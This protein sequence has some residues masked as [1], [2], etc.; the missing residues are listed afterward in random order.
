M[1]NRLTPINKPN[2]LKALFASVLLLA[3][4]GPF[5]QSGWSQAVPP[6][7]VHEIDLAFTYNTFRQNAVYGPTFWQQGGSME[8]SA[9]AYR[10]FGIAMALSGAQACNANNSGIDVDTLAIVF[11]PRYTYKHRRLAIFGESLIGES[12]AFAGLYPS[13]QGNM[14]TANAFA[15]RIGG[16][17]DLRLSHHFALRPIEAHWLR[18]QFPNGESNVQNGTLVGAGIVFRLHR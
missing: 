15:L 5:V 8:L 3:G 14:S 11:G 9:E 12:K 7:N 17:L 6:H 10:G 16:G 18:T 13:S 1:S 2:R 4:F